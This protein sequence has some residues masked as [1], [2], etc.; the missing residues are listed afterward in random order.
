MAERGDSK[1]T[2]IAKLDCISQLAV[3]YIICNIL[4]TFSAM[5]LDFRSFS[6]SLKFRQKRYHWYHLR[7]GGEGGEM[8]LE[9]VRRIQESQAP[10]WN[11]RWYH[12]TVSP[13]SVSATGGEGCKAS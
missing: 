9:R 1:N 7:G 11:K 2:K 6:F 10:W 12:Q 4:L 8:A 13:P 5:K 3:N